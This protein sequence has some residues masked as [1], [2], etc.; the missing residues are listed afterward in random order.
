MLAAPGC[1]W[2]VHENGGT[3]LLTGTESHGDAYNECDV[4]SGE[5]DR[6]AATI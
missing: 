4:P 3:G 2:L 6:L 1:Q 5:C